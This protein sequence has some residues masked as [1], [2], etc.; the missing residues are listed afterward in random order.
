[1]H[2]SN[3]VSGSRIYDPYTMLIRGTPES[4]DLGELPNGFMVVDMSLNSMEVVW[5]TIHN[6]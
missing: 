4:H 5:I 6:V 1:M 2:G 3:P